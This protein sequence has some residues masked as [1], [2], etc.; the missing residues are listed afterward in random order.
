ML[1]NINFLIWFKVAKPIKIKYG[2]ATNCTLVLNGA[3]VLNKVFNK[4]FTRIQL[5]KFANY[6]N[7]NK[8]DSYISVLIM[9]GY[10]LLVSG[11]DTRQ[12]YTISET[13]LQVIK[14]LNESYEKELYL[15]CSTHGIE[16]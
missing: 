11:K 10:L 6:Y 9:K 12:Y 2:L 3:Y 14:E 16:L 8:I 4:P 5:R 15:F 13:G 1:G 7:A